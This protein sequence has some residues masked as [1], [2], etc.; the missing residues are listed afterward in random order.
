MN[1]SFYPSNLTDDQW[2][3]LKPLIPVFK[4]GRPRK[5]SMR[6]VVDAILYLVRT[7]CQW[8]YL[9]HDFPPKSTVFEYYSAWRKTGTLNRIHDA[10]RDGVRKQQAPQ[11]PRRTASIDSQ[12]VETSSGGSDRGRDNAKNVNGRK[13][14]ILVDSLGLL[15]AVT[16]TAAD[17]DDAAAA[18]SLLKVLADPPLGHVRRVFGDSKYHNH[19]LHGWVADQEQYEMQ[20]VRR[21]PGATG[22][23]RLPIRWVVERT[24]AWF[25]KNRRLTVDRE[26]QPES[27]E[28]MLRWSMVQLMLHRLRP[29]RDEAEYQY[30]QSA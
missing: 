2:A 8:R 4:T 21:P 22:W 12:S 16:V 26:K 23:V 27:S 29:A 3:L 13:R 10:L 19:T 25:L 5:T 7:G 15:L 6:S 28:A 9:P 11:R 14:H 24:F 17:V 20:I 30:G 18:P 1:T